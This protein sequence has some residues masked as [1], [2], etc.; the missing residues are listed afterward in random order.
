MESLGKYV[1]LH[2]FY[3]KNGYGV[4]SE[5]TGS[6]EFDLEGNITEKGL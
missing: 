1:C 4:E 2:S 3:G 6:F 5:T